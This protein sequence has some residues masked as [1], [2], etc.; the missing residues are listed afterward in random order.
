LDEVAEKGA[1]VGVDKMSKGIRV[2]VEGRLVITRDYVLSSKR[3]KKSIMLDSVDNEELWQLIMI[4]MFIK[5][6]LLLHF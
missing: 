2:I 6:T 4:G 1:Y 3:E 5:W